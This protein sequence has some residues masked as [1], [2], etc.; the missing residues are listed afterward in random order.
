MARN[1]LTEDKPTLFVDQYG[2]KVVA[3]SAKALCE[4]V[5]YRKASKQYADKRD[6]RVVWNGYVVGPY[7]FTAFKW[8][9]VPVN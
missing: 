3:A 7:W 8:R 1:A 5:G 6:G 2:K 9:E 4:A